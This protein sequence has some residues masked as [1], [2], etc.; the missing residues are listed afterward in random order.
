MPANFLHHPS[1]YRDPSGFIFE[2]D[3]VL[4]RQVN[5]IF[6]EHFDLFIQSGCYEKLVKNGLLIPHEMI[7]NNLTGDEEWYATLKPEKLKYISYPYEWPFDMLKDAALLTL[8]LLKESV[9]A[10]LI[11]KDATPYNIQWHNGKLI[12][13]D[14]LSFEKYD[15]T[16]PWIAYR[17]FCEHFLSPLLLSHHSKLPLQEILLAY[18]DGIPLAVTRS[19]LPWKTKFSIHTYLHIH[20]HAKYSN[21][22]TTETSGKTSFSKKKLLNLVTSL[23]VLINK[24]HLPESKSTWSGYY[25]EASQRKDYFEYKQ[26]IIQQWLVKVNPSSVADLGANTG[27]FS[28]LS[29]TYTIQTI[30]TDFDAYCIN[31]LYKTIKKSGEKNV[32]PLI[33]DLSKPSPAI[34]VNNEERG[35]FIQRTSVDMAFALALIHHLAI[36]RNIPFEKMADFLSRICHHLIIE[37]VPKSDEKIRLML[38]GK[39]DIYTQYSEGNFITAFNKYFT[40]EDK[41]AIP[42][43]ERTIYLMKKNEG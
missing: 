20:L 29:A 15:E 12:F 28:K 11:L 39:N 40:T 3:G 22:R 33:I 32:L 35:S 34:G 37:F 42:G 10:S 9:N 41:K 2:K 38:T 8:K 18:S 27:E 23:E 1:S 19:L 36:G 43:S 5:K 14:S 13:I 26:K 25:D 4:Y 24:L 6:A 30:A 31:S 16:M 17:Q 7:N 21:K